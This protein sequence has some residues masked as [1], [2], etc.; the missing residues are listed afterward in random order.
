[1][2]CVPACRS[3]QRD[4]TALIIHCKDAASP[5]DDKEGASPRNLAQKIMAE[6]KRQPFG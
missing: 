6:L 1:M 4:T 5:I 3:K 2:L